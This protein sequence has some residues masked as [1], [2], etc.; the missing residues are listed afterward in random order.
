MTT[1]FTYNL[2]KPAICSIKEEAKYDNLKD[3]LQYFHFDKW[4]FLLKNE[5]FVHC[6]CKPFS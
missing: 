2:T 1:K 3:P 4:F 5:S 6:L